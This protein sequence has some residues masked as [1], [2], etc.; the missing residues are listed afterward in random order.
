MPL[1][2]SKAQLQRYRYDPFEYI[3][4]PLICVFVFESVCDLGMIYP[5]EKPYLY[6]AKTFDADRHV[7]PA[8]RI[9][10][11]HRTGLDWAPFPP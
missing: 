2:I 10:P 11:S 9:P 5:G 7:D 4:A 1:P 8:E 6:G 3:L